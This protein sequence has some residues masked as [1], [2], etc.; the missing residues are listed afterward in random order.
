MVYINGL[1]AVTLTEEKDITNT[2]PI[3][4]YNTTVMVATRMPGE[5]GLVGNVDVRLKNGAIALP[6]ILRDD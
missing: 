2:A 6:A 1:M 4:V 3:P 5:A